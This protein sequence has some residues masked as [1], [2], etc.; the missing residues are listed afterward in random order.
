V[1]TK[2]LPGVWGGAWE[3]LRPD[4]PTADPDEAIVN[5]IAEHMV[6]AYAAL[7]L[8]QSNQAPLDAIFPYVTYVESQCAR[9]FDSDALYKRI[10]TEHRDIL[11]PLAPRTGLFGHYQLRRIAL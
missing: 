8:Q 5:A 9:R 4:T 2:S 11:A 6:Q 10:F 7:R 3:V 1:A